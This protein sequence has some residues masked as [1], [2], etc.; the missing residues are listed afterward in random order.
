MST[1]KICDITKIS[2]MV[3]L[4]EKIR[5]YILYVQC[6]YI[7]IFY[8]HRHT[9]TNRDKTGRKYTK[10]LAVVVLGAVKLWVNLFLLFFHFF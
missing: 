6:I 4:R 1:A 5:I 8:T 10:M 7:Y 9:C 3:M 2:Y